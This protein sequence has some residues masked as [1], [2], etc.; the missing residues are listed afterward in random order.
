[1]WYFLSLGFL[2]LGIHRL[3]GAL[4]ERSA[5]PEVRIQAAGCR[6]WWA[7]R[8]W[9]FLACLPPIGHT[10]MRGQSN[11]ILL[12]LLCGA[13][14]AT[15]RGQRTRSGFWLAGAICLKVYPAFLLLFPLWRRDGRALAACALGL[16]VGLL[17]IPAAVFG[18]AGTVAHYQR[19][20]EV[21]VLPA[22][23]LGSDTSRADEIMD[24]IAN[25]SQSLQSAMHNSLHLNRYTRPPRPSAGVLWGAR[26]AGC[27][28]TLLTLL[29][30]VRRRSPAATVLFFGALVAVM[31][32]NTPVCHTHY[33]SFLVPLVI[34]LV[35]V[36]WQG[37][38]D[39]RL[40]PVLTT[41]LAM[42]ATVYILCSLPGLEVLR[43][44]GLTLYPALLLWL[45]GILALRRQADEG[46]TASAEPASPRLAA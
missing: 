6:R 36:A 34:G 25:D 40:G 5:D 27:I 14:A 4:E 18:I 38:S 29:A 9:P 1:L 42:N 44:L 3:A 35:T 26:L 7:L 30:A 33:F 11:P 39:L 24:S 15:L 37:R 32:L 22:L 46:L 12:A 10:L 17:L 31:L 16:M 8:L 20:N 19:Y 2:A 28:L 13:V 21:F 23:G 41:L 45:A 43:D